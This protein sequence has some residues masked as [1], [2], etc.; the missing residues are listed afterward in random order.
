[1]GGSGGGGG[2]RG[3]NR[4]PNLVI[5]VVW[6]TLIV[7]AWALVGLGV[8]EAWSGKSCLGPAENHIFCVPGFIKGWGDAG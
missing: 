4:R 3:R 2:G 7:G 1:M 6:N 8:L 5:F